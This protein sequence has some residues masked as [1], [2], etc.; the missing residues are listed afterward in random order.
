[1]ILGNIKDFDWYNEPENVSF[2]ES[3]LQIIAQEY[4]DFWQNIDKG[5][6]KDNGH[7]F[8]STRNDNF[9][10]V[11]KWF[12]EE[13]IDSAQCGAMVRVDEH[14]WIKIGLL[15]SNIYNP[16]IGEVVAIQGSSDWSIT[17]INSSFKTVWFKIKRCEQDFV[18]SYSLDGKTFHITRIIHMSKA[19]D[20]LKIGAY[21]CSPKET[22]FECVLEEISISNL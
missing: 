18:L 15:S 13:I 5:F 1:M 12:F 9:V 6:A 8:A 4:T 3:G 19:R 17:N 11:C 2:T 16:Q 10:F 14:N 7:F 20:V 22:P 21:A